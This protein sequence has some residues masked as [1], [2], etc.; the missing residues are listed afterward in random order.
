M[1]DA[2]GVAGDKLR[3]LIERIE[4]L[5]EEKKTIAD[6]I[7]DVKSKAKALGYDVSA[8]NAIIKLRKK[9]A[10]ERAEEEAILDA[11][12]AALGMLPQRDLFDEAYD[13][14]PR[15]A[16]QVVDGMQTEAGRA[17]LLA[18][19]DIM[20]EREEAEEQ[21]SPE[22]AE[23]MQHPGSL[24]IGN[25]E[26]APAAANRP[27]GDDGMVRMA[28]TEA[29]AVTAGETATNSETDA[30]ISRP[31]SHIERPEIENRSDKEPSE[32]NGSGEMQDE[33]TIHLPTLSEIGPNEDRS[34][35]QSPDG[36]LNVVGANTGGGHVNSSAMRA[37]QSDPT[38]NSGE[39]PRQSSLPVT[40]KY[41]PNCQ[42][43]DHCRSGTRDHCYSCRVAMREDAA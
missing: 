41:R 2:H 29:S 18:A 14:N 19:V 16:K 23:E 30:A 32:S 40:H 15:L 27:N 4:R 24:P 35:G 26:P 9:D 28:R 22:T 6:D 17:A 37:G 42:H 38:S 3:S 20:I 10:N 21:N 36:G 1:L 39:E 43:R 5:E 12:M 31:V 33:F 7:K 13:A 25:P 11:Y 8:I 34:E